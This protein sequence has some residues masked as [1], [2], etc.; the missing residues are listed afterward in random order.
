MNKNIEDIR[1]M[2]KFLAVLQQIRRNGITFLLLTNKSFRLFR[3]LGVHVTPVHF[4]SPIP[5]L[6][7]LEQHPYILERESALPGIR[8]NDAAQLDFMQEVIARYKS[9][10]DFPSHPTGQPGEYYSLSGYFD[11]GSAVAMHSLIRHLQPKKIIEVGAGYST[12][13]IANA[14]HLNTPAEYPAEI[15]AIDPYPNEERFAGMPAEVQL[16]ARKVEDVEVAFLTRLQANDILSIDS[17]HAIRTGGNVT[18][19]YLE[20]LPRLAPGVFVHIHDIFLPYEYPK[21]FFERR[22]FWNEQYLLQAFLIG[23][24]DFDVVWGQKYAEMRFSE[25]YG[26]VFGNRAYETPGTSS[27][28]FWIRRANPYHN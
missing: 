3:R 11:Y 4:Y 20:V 18:F 21:H 22:H 17:S 10:C 2:N 8:M 1:G 5:D 12:R 24:A 15:V 23:N 9:E 27:Y 13:V 7:E 25:T 28:S 26:K 16:L 14:V 6:R 19:L